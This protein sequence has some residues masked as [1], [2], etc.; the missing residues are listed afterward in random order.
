MYI[1]KHPIVTDFATYVTV[2][3]QNEE[4]FGLSGFDFFAIDKNNSLYL[5]YFSGLNVIPRKH[6]HSIDQNLQ[7]KRLCG[8][9]A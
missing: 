3:M 2:N 9:L 8:I 1:L 5:Q 6:W 4:I 7:H